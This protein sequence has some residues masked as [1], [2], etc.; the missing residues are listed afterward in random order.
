[1][2]TESPPSNDSARPYLPAATRVG[3]VA[4][5]PRVPFRGAADRWAGPF[6]HAY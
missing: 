4:P 6:P 1:M 5:A 2:A 3:A